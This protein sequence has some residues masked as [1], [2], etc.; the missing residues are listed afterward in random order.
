V[1]VSGNERG[2]AH[3][4][5]PDDD[6]FGDE[7]IDAAVARTAALEARPVGEHVEVYDAV[8]RILRDALADPAGSAEAAG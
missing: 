7:R 8:H 2:G 1:S 5:A 4:E 3:D 6:G